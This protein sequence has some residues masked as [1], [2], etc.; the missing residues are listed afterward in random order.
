MAFRTISLVSALGPNSMVVTSGGPAARGPSARRC[1]GEL[2]RP[3]LPLPESKAAPPASQPQ[4]RGVVVNGL[5]PGL[6]GGR[7]H[8]PLGDAIKWGQLETRGHPQLDLALKH[9]RQ[10]GR[11]APAPRRAP[12]TRAGR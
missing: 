3:A 1:L 8:H 6:L 9:R 11:I 7:R 2:E 4:V 12:G 5:Q 10:T